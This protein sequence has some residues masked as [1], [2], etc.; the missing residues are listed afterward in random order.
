MAL[1]RLGNR[2]DVQSFVLQHVG[3]AKLGDNGDCLRSLEAT[4]QPHQ[5]SHRILVCVVQYLSGDEANFIKSFGE[6]ILSS[7]QRTKSS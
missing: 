7:S 4:D 2:V 3:D 6:G 5:V 1:R